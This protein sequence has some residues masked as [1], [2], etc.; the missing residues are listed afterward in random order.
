MARKTTV[1]LQPKTAQSVAKLMRQ[2]LANKE[3]AKEI[4]KDDL[5]DHPVHGTVIVADS[6]RE[7]ADQIANDANDILTPAADDSAK[8][9]GAKGSKS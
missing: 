4:T 8:S 1:K 2:A 5:I 3:I 7:I 9:D 6:L